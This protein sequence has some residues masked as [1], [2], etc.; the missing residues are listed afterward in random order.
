MDSVQ[1]NFEVLFPEGFYHGAVTASFSGEESCR[2]VASIGVY[3]S[4][5]NAANASVGNAFHRIVI[6]DQYELRC[7]FNRQSSRCRETC[8][9][10]TAGADGGVAGVSRRAKSC[11]FLWVYMC[12]YE[13]HC[14]DELK[15][16]G[17][18]GW[19]RNSASKIRDLTKTKSGCRQQK[20]G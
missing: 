3:M 10:A 14:V 18:Q 7:V 13:M 9:V 12:K 19:R 6:C 16:R 1:R 4:I 17:R 11:K 20:D 8:A 15:Y 2:D 5:G